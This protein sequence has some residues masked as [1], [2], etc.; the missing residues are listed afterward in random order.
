[1]LLQYV[2]KYILY[3]KVLQVWCIF[4]TL[5][6]ETSKHFST[7]GFVVP[8][9]VVLKKYFFVKCLKYGQD[10]LIQATSTA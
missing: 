8:K 7:F 3:N 1:M 9:T 5:N 2:Y 4:V 10:I 6:L